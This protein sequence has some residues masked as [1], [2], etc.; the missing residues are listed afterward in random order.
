MSGILL[1]LYCIYIRRLRDNRG[2][3]IVE[4][5]VDF[6]PKA[7]LSISQKRPELVGVLVA[8]SMHLIHVDRGPRVV[9]SQDQDQSLTRT[10][11]YKSRISCKLL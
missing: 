4:Q 2:S 11:S 6:I 8:Y 7:K 5:K 1:Y 3:R 9:T 10:C